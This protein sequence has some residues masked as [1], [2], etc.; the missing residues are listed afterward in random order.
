MS[1][2]GGALGGAVNGYCH[3]GREL[4]GRATDASERG[5]SGSRCHDGTLGHFDRVLR[6][7]GEVDA[8]VDDASVSGA[9]KL[10]VAVVGRDGDDAVCGAHGRLDENVARPGLHRRA[11]R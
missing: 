5:V 8:R 11:E 6:A 1:L 2:V 7:A 4:I 10:A 3:F 9:A